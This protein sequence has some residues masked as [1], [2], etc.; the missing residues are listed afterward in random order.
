FGVTP[1]LTALGKIIGGGLPVGAYG[2]RRDLMAH[3]A[4]SGPVYQAGTMSGNPLVVAAGLACLRKIKDDPSVY[5]R[6]EVVGSQIE[7]RLVNALAE[8]GLAGCVQRVGGML[9]VFF[10]PGRVSHWDDA[11]TADRD[12][13][14]R[15]FQAAYRRGVLLPPSQ[16]EAWFVTDSHSA[17]IDEALTALV[18][19]IAEVA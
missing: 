17:V 19:A 1:D 18:E 11:A 8:A 14:A 12:R 4:P 2:G 9:T 10:G 6:I 7:D 5:D 16:F 13:F 15:F 3:I